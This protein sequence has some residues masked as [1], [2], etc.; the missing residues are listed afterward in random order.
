MEQLPNVPSE[1]L[2]LAMKD[3]EK[4]KVDPAFK[5]DMGYW[6]C[7]TTPDA[8]CMVCLAGSVMVKSLEIPIPEPG[9]RGY[10]THDFPLYAN[11]FNALDCFRCGR[12]VEGFEDLLHEPDISPYLEERMRQVMKQKYFG[13]LGMVVVTSH[14]DDPSQWEKDMHGLIEVLKGLGL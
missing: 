8:P 2:E 6:C 13:P 9:V 10:Y 3:Y 14:D 4:T 11:H 1:L 7:K 5:I 12:V